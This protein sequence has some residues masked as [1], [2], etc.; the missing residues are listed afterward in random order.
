MLIPESTPMVGDY[1]SGDHGPVFPI[2]GEGDKHET[3]KVGE[4]GG[5][6]H[7]NDKNTGRQGNVFW[8]EINNNNKI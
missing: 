5:N 7:I 2:K 8:I 6:K 4:E 1:S 3:N